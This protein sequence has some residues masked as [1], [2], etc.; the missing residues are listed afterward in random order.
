MSVKTFL[1]VTM[2]GLMTLLTGFA[3]DFSSAEA[4]EINRHNVTNKEAAPN[5]VR[6]DSLAYV[7]VG[8]AWL[9]NIEANELP[10][11][12][13]GGWRRELDNFALD[14]GGS[15][16]LAVGNEET[17]EVGVSGTVTLMGHYFFNG[18]ADSS[19]YLG[20]GMGYGFMAMNK[21]TDDEALAEEG[22]TYGG[23]GLHGKVA[24][25]F[26]AMR[27]STIRLF[28]Q[29]DATLPFYDLEHDCSECGDGSNS[30][31]GPTERE[32]LYAPIFGISIG[33]AWTKGNNRTVTVRHM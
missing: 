3:G 2:A 23:A 22:L 20:M 28:M 24:L 19:P 4:R 7:T 11:A 14:L 6:D 21:S 16:Y 12:I 29:L 15:L 26:E 31:S 25:G 8:P 18:V 1:T 33:G 5:R 10:M 9:P 27:S 32:A 17:E 13:G 30:M